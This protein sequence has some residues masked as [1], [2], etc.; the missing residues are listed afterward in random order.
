MI[1]ADNFVPYSILSRVHL[2]HF[3]QLLV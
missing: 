3:L 2:I 1:V